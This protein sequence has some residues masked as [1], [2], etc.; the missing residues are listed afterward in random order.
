MTGPAGS[1]AADAA[2]NAYYETR[3]RVTEYIPGAYAREGAARTWLMVTTIPDPELNVV[4]VG[5]RRDLREVEA[6]AREIATT[7]VPWSFQVRGDVDPELKRLATG[8]GK[9]GTSTQPLLLWDAGSLPDLLDAPGITGFLLDLRGEA[10]AT[11]WCDHGSRAAARGTGRHG[12][13]PCRTAL[14]PLRLSLAM[15]RSHQR[16]DDRSPLLRRGW[17]GHSRHQPFGRKS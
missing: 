5:H 16:D 8:Y 17:T 2:V 9:T 10:V 11:C 13:Q 15:W 4:S 12:Q 3:A 6:L 1:D 7:G 14:R